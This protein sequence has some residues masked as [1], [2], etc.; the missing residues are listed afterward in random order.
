MAYPYDHKIRKTEQETIPFK[1]IGP[2]GTEVNEIAEMATVT[3]YTVNPVYGAYR[4]GLHAWAEGASTSAIDIQVRPWVDHGQTIPGPALNM[5]EIGS[6]TMTTVASIAATSG[7]DGSIWIV[8]P[9]DDA[10]GANP[11]SS[12]IAVGP[13]SHGIAVTVDVNSNTVGEVDFELICQ[14]VQ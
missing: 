11:G 1:P 8:V 9:G 14:R 3:T 7:S 10:A 4:L 13:V 2:G 5:F 6:G 12:A